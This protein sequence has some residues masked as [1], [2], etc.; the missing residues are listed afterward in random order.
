MKEL[1]QLT[2]NFLGDSITE[3]VWATAPELCYVERVGA[4]LGCKVNNCGICGTRIAPQ[5]QPSP[6]A[7]F[8]RDFLQRA[9]LMPDA[10]LVFVFGGTNDFGHGDADFGTITDESADTFCGA[11]RNLAKYLTNRYGKC[12]L[13]YILPLHRFNEDNPLGDGSR[14]KP[15][16]PLKEYVKAERTILQ[17][18]GI[19]FLDLSDIFPQPEVSTPTELFQDG[20]H[21]TNKGHELI[22]ERICQ[23]VRSLTL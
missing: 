9:P 7:D 22:A 3:G 20:L 13:C 19:A 6:S 23:Y 8:D 11:F 12:N 21:P 15:T 18:L 16:L 4:K 5:T 2:I 1:N 10:D 14:N 17:Q